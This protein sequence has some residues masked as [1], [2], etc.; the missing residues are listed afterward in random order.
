MLNATFVEKLAILPRSVV[1]K[2]AAAVTQQQPDGSAVVP[3][4][5][6]SN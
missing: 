4:S 3:I 6:T 5:Q 1:Q 2:P